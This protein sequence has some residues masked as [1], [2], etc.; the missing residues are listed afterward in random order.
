[1]GKHIQLPRNVHVGK[2]SLE[3]LENYKEKNALVVTGPTTREVAGEKAAEILET[4]L[5]IVEE[6]TVQE[7]ERV[8]KELEEI[9]RDL[10]IAVGGGKIIDVTKVA[11][12][13]SGV[14]F[15]SVPTAA[16][17]DGVASQ[18]ASLQDNGTRESKV[19][20]TPEG[21]IV[22]F[23][24]I[25]NCPYE[26]IRGGVGDTLSNFTA[27]KDW[28]LGHTV[29]NEYYGDYASSLSEMVAKLIQNR[30]REIKERTPEG[31]ST[32]MEALISS[33]AAMG[34]A[35]SSR[36]ASGSEH[37]FSHTLDK[38]ADKPALHG[39]QC[40]VGS[41]AMSYLQGEAWRDIKTALERADCPT[42]AEELGI[43]DETAVKAM[44][45]AKEIKPQRYTILEHIDVDE[46]IA[47]NALKNTEV[48]K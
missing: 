12:Y 8:K 38:I 31:I 19:T 35:G 1:M 45:K 40:G 30:V 15:I 9:D 7:A 14:E 28:K 21:V 43:K 11:T 34:I 44:A 25:K 3:K 16:S 26:L 23:N 13:E 41:I 36:P 27:V 17:N 6:P 10:A 39:E 22:D 32:L 47:E 46:D 5:K 29:K 20:H 33:G 4:D 2:K 24:I 42:T 18:M 37:K 48:I